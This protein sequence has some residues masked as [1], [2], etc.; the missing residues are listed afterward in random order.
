MMELKKTE[1]FNVLTTPAIPSTLPELF[2]LPDWL[3]LII[4]VSFK[5]HLLWK[6]YPSH[7]IQFIPH[8]HVISYLN[9]MIHI[10]KDTCQD[11]KSSYYISWFFFLTLQ[12]SKLHEVGILCVFFHSVSLV[13]GTLPGTEKGNSKIDYYLVFHFY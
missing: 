1:S 13:W 9:I 11:L 3:L 10:F 4:K 5:Y 6:V 7:P 12:E 8:F 2:A